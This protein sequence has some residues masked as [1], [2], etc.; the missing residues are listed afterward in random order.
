MP[1][2]SRV[3]LECDGRAV[4]SH[5]TG[6]ANHDAGGEGSDPDAD[7]GKH[8]TRGVDKQGRAW[9]QVKSWFGY[10]ACI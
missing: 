1:S 2:W 6:Q 3:H 8:E 7:W 5:S 9:K 10:T 4:A